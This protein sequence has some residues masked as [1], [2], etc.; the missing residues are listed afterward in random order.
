MGHEHTTKPADPL[1][2]LKREPRG[3]KRGVFVDVSEVGWRKTIGVFF[4]FFFFF[5]WFS[6][7]GGEMVAL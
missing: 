3:S 5:L 1:H 4:F 6:A 2:G 7:R